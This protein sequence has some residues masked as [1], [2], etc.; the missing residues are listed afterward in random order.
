MP[1]AT[2]STTNP[3]AEHDALDILSFHV[4]HGDCTL[5]EYKSEGRIRFRLLADAGERL[6]PA[7]VTHLRSNPRNDGRPDLDV[8]VLSHVDADHQGGL[9]A[10]LHEN[11]GIGH[12]LGPC[13]P[14]FRRLAWL[15]AERVRNAVERAQ[16]FQN[17]LAR[18]SI[19][20][21]FPFEGY[22]ERH[23]EGRIV[24][25]VIS[26]AARAIKQLACAGADEIGNLLMRY[27][28]PLMWLLETERDL[29]REDDYRDVRAAFDGRIMLTP[30]DLAGGLP[31]LAGIDVVDVTRAARATMAADYEPEFFGNAV[32][33]DTSLNVIVDCNLGG[34]QRRRILLSGDQENWS[35]IAAQHP[36]GLGI[37]V[38]KAPHHGG[39]VYL[40]DREAA[41]DR[42]YLWMRPRS[43]FVSANGR[44]KLPRTEFR[45]A[46]LAV[47][48]T[49]VCP[50]RRSIEPLVAGTMLKPTEASCFAAYGCSPPSE[51]TH[52]VLTLR[53]DTESASEYACVQGSGHRGAA[54]IVV[55]RQSVVSPSEAF[56][57]WTRG[58]MEKHA[59]WITT[60]LSEISRSF[61]QRVPEAERITTS[62]QQQPVAWSS[63]EAAA[64]HAERHGLVADP[65][66]VLAFGRSQRLFWV[67]RPS[68]NSQGTPSLYRLPGK[69][70]LETASA[71]LASVSN[72]VLSIEEKASLRAIDDIALLRSGDWTVLSA[73]LAAQLLVPLDVIKDEVLPRLWMQIREGFT[74]AI[75]DPLQWPHSALRILKLSNRKGAA[76]V[77]N[78]CGAQWRPLWEAQEVDEAT[79]LLLRDR[80]ADVLLA[81]II[82]DGKNGLQVHTKWMEHARFLGS[83]YSS[84]R[85]YWEDRFASV[86]G[87]S[88]WEILW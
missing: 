53:A 81:D 44:H 48:A 19:P 69:V 1:A 57:R 10:L 42:V 85:E 64:R 80:S 18:R 15:F 38:L 60:Q 33:N 67:S 88:D 63:I 82:Q 75:C 29:A 76:S 46:L 27:P 37:D 61:H 43:V 28:M 31:P 41:I 39:R 6:P 84:R 26:P 54:P 5:I 34:T 58:E 77:P 9:P 40:D 71:W 47:G 68:R 86:F 62:L 25:S 13:L 83:S 66:P 51:T 56:V 45:Q 73:L 12:Y 65:E 50:N 21:T 55:L 8:L 16:D 7:L 72:I 11:V 24:V 59:K 22:T 49:L 87:G 74:A 3:P 78:L 4:G 2:T 79:W 32:L 70:D 30:D 52:S 36:A 23:A 20:I 14:A 35:Y 17:E